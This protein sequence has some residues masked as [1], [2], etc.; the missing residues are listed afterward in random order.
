MTVCSEF[1]RWGQNNLKE[2]ILNFLSS[3]VADSMFPSLFLL[4]CPQIIFFDILT[5]IRPYICYW[6]E[7]V[8]G[9][10]FS[11]QWLLNFCIPSSSEL[12]GPC[13][14]VNCSCILAGTE[15]EQ[16]FLLKKGWYP[17]WWLGPGVRLCLRGGDD[18]VWLP[19]RNPSKIPTKPPPSHFL[20]KKD[21]PCV[22]HILYSAGCFFFGI[23]F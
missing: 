4:H 3:M 14:W 2:S 22:F 12:P 9:R 6:D 18:A 19:I 10:H 17:T 15:P 11:G 7:S 1:I 16:S 23:M 8:S 21:N 20:F 5:V 13:L